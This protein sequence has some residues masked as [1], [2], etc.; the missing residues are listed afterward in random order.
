[1]QFID[2]KKQYQLIEATIQQKINAVLEHGKF[3][4]GPEIQELEEKLA[5]FVGSKFC[6]SV[7]SG[8]DA[9]LMSL[10]AYDV[11]PG[12]AIFTTPFTF[13]STAEVISLLGATPIFVDIDP[14]TF[15]LNPTKFKK[16]ISDYIKGIKQSSKIPDGLNPKGIIAV[17][18][19]GLPADYD[20]INGIANEYGL[21]VI[22]DAAQSFGGMYK[23]KMACN[24]TDIAATSFFP[25]KPLGCYGDGGAI[26]TN[27]E[28]LFNKIK[29]LRIHGQGANKYDNLRIGINGR[30]DTIQ[31]AILLAKLEL[32]NNE[33]EKRQNVAEVYS[34]G[35]KEIVEIP[36]IPYNYKSV[37]AQYS[38]LSDN[39]DKIKSDL[40]E[41][42]IPSA[43]YYVKPLHLQ[44]A[45]SY[46]GYEE[47]SMPVSEKT[48]K[49]VLSLPMH[50]YLERKEQEI[51]IEVIKKL[52]DLN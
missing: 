15:N 31:A 2:L 3:I 52:L 13:I 35:L 32:F 27:D 44:T 48:S 46:L 41:V 11:G 9:L 36:Y 30:L 4:M 28:N 18:L 22:E 24:L 23:N 37:W 16:V 26:F 50:P 20:S 39:R 10:M 38:I 19:F 5:A 29:S 42:N 33:I 8:T 45:F 7:S 6:I 14:K 43:V 25:A 1:M 49:R 51:I 34:E 40:N 47:G 21:F 17:D 12:D